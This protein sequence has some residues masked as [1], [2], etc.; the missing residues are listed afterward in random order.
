[1]DLAMKYLL[2]LKIKINPFFVLKIADKIN[3][4]KK[5]TKT[6]LLKKNFFQLRS[7]QI[8]HLSNQEEAIS[9][10]FFDLKYIIFILFY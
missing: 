3:F 10:Y 7:S 2:V 1:M 4:T 9:L 5:N 6:Y 8:L